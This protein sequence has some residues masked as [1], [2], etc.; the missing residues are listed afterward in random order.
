MLKNSDWIFIWTLFLRG[1]CILIK[2][3]T[4]ESQTDI[5]PVHIIPC[6]GAVTSLVFFI[7][8]FKDGMA[9]IN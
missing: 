6:R 9:I 4:L 8:G 7:V 2:P 5:D 1:K 3:E